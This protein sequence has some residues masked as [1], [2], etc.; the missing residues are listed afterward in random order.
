VLITRLQP[1][2]S[3][4]GLIVRHSDKRGRLASYFPAQN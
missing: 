4:F 2:N 1:P 3:C